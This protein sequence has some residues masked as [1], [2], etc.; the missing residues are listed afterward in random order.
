MML[1]PRI[2]RK[3]VLYSPGCLPESASM[4]LR[5]LLS[6]PYLFIIVFRVRN[7]Q[8]FYQS[9]SPFISRAYHTCI[10]FQCFR[11]LGGRG[12][13]ASWDGQPAPHS[14]SFTLIERFG[15]IYF[16]DVTVLNLTDIAPAAASGE[17]CPMLSPEVPPLKRPSVISAH[18]LPK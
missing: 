7:S 17:I 15:Y 1:P 8:L 4:L 18:S 16:D 9:H 13:P 14:V 2:N 6:F 5:L 12:L 11:H 3:M 10:R